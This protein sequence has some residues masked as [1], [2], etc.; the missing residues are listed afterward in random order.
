MATNT[1]SGSVYFSGL[2]NGTDF[3]TV[4][5]QLKE[6]E[7][8]TKNRL[9]SW[10]SDWQVRYDAFEEVLKSVQT[11]KSALTS[12]NSVDKFVTKTASSSQTTVAE[13]TA[14]ASAVDGQHT[15]NVS[16]L[17]SNAI[18][19]NTSAT[20]AS[21]N[22]AINAT[23]HAVTFAYTYKDKEYS[24]SVPKGTSLQSFANLVNNSSTNPGISVSI[25]QTGSGY[26]YQVAGKDSGTAA[27]LAIHPCE[28]QGMSA[29]GG[30]VW[31]S[32]STV[33]A[34][35]QV[36]DT[37]NYTA[38]LQDG[39][40]VSFS[41]A[42]SAT[43]DDL[44]QKLA[45]YGSIKV[46]A[47]ESTGTLGL[48]GVIAL[49]RTA[50]SSNE[51]EV[52]TS[53]ATGGSVFTLPAD[54]LNTGFDTATLAGSTLSLTDKDGNTLAI[55]LSSAYS[56]GMDVAS[57]SRQLAQD[58]N[59]GYA[60]AYQTATGKTWTGGDVA[61]LTSTTAGD[62]SVTQSLSLDG[63]KGVDFAK[64]VAP[65][66]DKASFSTAFS[67]AM[68]GYTAA[69]ALGTG[70][71]MA[72]TLTDSAGNTHTVQVPSGST[73]TELVDAL[74]AGVA[75][76]GTGFANA[77]I[78]LDSSG[79][80]KAENIANIAGPGIKGSVTQ[81]GTWA[82]QKASDAVFTVDNWPQQLTSS[83]NTLSDVVE[84]LTITLRSA[85]TT[86]ISVAT[87]SDSVLKSIQSVLD[88][89]NSVLVTIN[90]LS[91]VEE[92]SDST[93]V[94]GSALTGNYGV[95]L[96][97]SRLKTTMSGKPAGFQ[98]ITG[99]DLLSGDLVASLSQIGIKTCSVEGDE[100]YGL[101]VIA[102]TAAVESLQTMDQEAFNKALTDNVDALVN[103]FAS[104]GQ[105]ST[106]SSDFRY[107]NHISGVAMAGT[108]DV[109]YDVSADGV[110][111]N[112]LIGGKPAAADSSMEGNWYTCTEG[113]AKSLA[114]Q[115]D[116]LAEGS[117]SGTVSIKQGLVPTMEDF[118]T[119]ELRYSEYD[120]DNNGA[121]RILQENYQQIMS[122]IQDKID[123]ETTRLSNWETRQRAY[124][125]R[126]E[127]VLSK[128]EGIQSTLKSQISSLSSSSSK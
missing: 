47:D 24:L 74:N 110:I 62:G 87:D 13:A 105:G 57:I 6:V 108:Y 36:Y 98:N 107:A 40:T 86:N 63:I 38:T 21:K 68:T 31:Q 37:Y 106:S 96:L 54:S 71:N 4:V 59:A 23:D 92:S 120:T 75:A 33:S 97:S 39:N 76:A 14:T 114:I 79:K 83:S 69:T 16:Q 56:T 118:F 73:M 125:S 29:T 101:F 65:F 20:F 82:I 116:N 100:N 67:T 66:N 25:I 84:G 51:K 7:S 109:S 48:S 9:E 80:I 17:A 5:D 89:V 81:S 94:S 95:Q 45:S 19:A 2:G 113:D 43:M 78:A 52:L 70:K 91:D 111:S 103:F 41:L 50:A 104:K 46:T 27:N 32:S 10:K 117:H 126:L 3:S 99:D 90:T 35:D 124:F 55:T 93:S 72:Y 88:A 34:T 60:A 18:W 121:L 128:Y 44:R 102:P 12:L 15:I 49:S 64:D 11:A 42:G 123:K 30:S 8:I 26:T 22:D 85:G 115:I 61:S 122:N 1:I 119:K 28:L 127:T 53:A 112:V 77:S 58:I